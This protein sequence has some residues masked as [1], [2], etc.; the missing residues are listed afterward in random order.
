MN[1]QQKIT[2]LNLAL[3]GLN[4][5]TVTILDGQINLWDNSTDSEKLRVHST[6]NASH[7]LETDQNDNV[8]RHGLITHANTVTVYDGVWPNLNQT[9]LPFGGTVQ[10]DI[11]NKK[12]FDQVTEAHPLQKLFCDYRFGDM[13]VG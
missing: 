8:L 3:V 5:N 7:W 1:T 13:G 12:R 4:G 10:V 2:V 6:P 11:Q 9:V